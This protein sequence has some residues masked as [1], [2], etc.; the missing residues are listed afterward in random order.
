M[1]VANRVIV[2]VGSAVVS[3]ILLGS[4]PGWLSCLA[5]VVSFSAGVFI[6]ADTEKSHATRKL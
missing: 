4:N 5:C 2:S 1:S 3:S 6:G